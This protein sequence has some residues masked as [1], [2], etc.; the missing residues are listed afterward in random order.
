MFP[1]DMLVEAFEIFLISE[2]RL[3]NTFPN[4]QFKIHYCKMCKLDQII[5]GGVS[6]SIL[7]SKC[8]VTE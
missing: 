1:Q 6:F 5:C 7:M 3:D 4:N 2:P 8:F